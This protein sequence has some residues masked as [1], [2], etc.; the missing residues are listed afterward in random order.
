MNRI[1]RRAGYAGSFANGKTLFLNSNAPL[2]PLQYAYQKPYAGFTF[3]LAKG[4]A[5]KTTWTYYGYYPGSVQNPAGLLQ[6]G[7]RT[8]MPTT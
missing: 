2:G 1:T 3:D 7:A 4:F 8:S 5:F 6:S